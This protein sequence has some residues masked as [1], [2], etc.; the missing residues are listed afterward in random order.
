MHK[1]NFP[2]KNEFIQSKS[3]L[4]SVQIQKKLSVS[5]K[6]TKTKVVLLKEYETSEGN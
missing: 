3:L 4:L 6:K 5:N 2:I 1:L